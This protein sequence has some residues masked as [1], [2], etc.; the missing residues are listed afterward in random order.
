MKKIEP[1]MVCAT[2][3]YTPSDTLSKDYSLDMGFGSV[4]L[5][6]NGDRIL[7]YIYSWINEDSEEPMKLYELEDKFKDEIN[8]GEEVLLKLNR[9]L[10]DLTYQYDKDNDEW[11]LI[12]Q[13]EGFA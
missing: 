8:Q 7:E 2:T 6:I 11:C 1:K 4:E 9:P 13:G 5:F 12:A 3:G 10:W